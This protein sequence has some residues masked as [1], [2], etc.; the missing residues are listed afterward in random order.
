MSGNLQNPTLY[1]IDDSYGGSCMAED[2]IGDYVRLTDYKKL[3]AAYNELK[4]KPHDT[5]LAAYEEK[6]R[7]AEEQDNADYPSK[8]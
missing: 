4:N 8:G 5:L 6:Q 1:D 3:L 7:Q 2:S